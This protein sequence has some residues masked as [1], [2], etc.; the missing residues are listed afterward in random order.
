MQARRELHHRRVDLRFYSREDGLFEVEG[1]LV[2]TKT[3]AF[4][5]PPATQAT[6]PG[7]PI[8]DI[9]V[10]V[11]LDAA[12]VVHDA[13]VQMRTTP[14]AR[15]AGVERTLEPLRGLR[16]AAGWNR[17]VREKLGGAAS[18][19]HV[20]EM[21]AQLATTAYQGLAPQRIARIDL[22]ESEPQRRAKV[23]SCYAY[24]AHGEV[25]AQLWPHLSRTDPTG[26]PATT[27]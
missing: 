12:M 7:E 11:V 4:R 19:A 3:E 1:S 10:T 22:P 2:D 25:V 21:L 6:A 13:R 20:V 24:A 23:D 27:R 17:Q 8:H 26:D 9:L 5:C 14:F 18:C 15:C 16:M